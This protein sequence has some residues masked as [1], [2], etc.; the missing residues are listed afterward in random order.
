MVYASLLIIILNHIQV[1]EL[2]FVKFYELIIIQWCV[3][4]QGKFNFKFFIHSNI[5]MTYVSDA[6]LDINTE[7]M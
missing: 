4:L 7:I 5:F 3:I 2:I 6:D 1:K